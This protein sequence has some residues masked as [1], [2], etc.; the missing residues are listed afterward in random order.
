MSQLSVFMQ[1]SVLTMPLVFSEKSPL[2]IRR[3]PL[4]FS[5]LVTLKLVPRVHRVTTENAANIVLLAIVENCHLV[6]HLLIVYL[7]TVT[8]IR[9]RVMW[10]QADVHVNIIQQVTI[11]NVVYRDTMVMLFVERRTIVKSARVLQVFLVHNWPYRN[12]MSSV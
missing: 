8:I 4:A 12:N 9:S 1:H 5:P 10:K 11:V 2:D 6:A 3:H 7:V